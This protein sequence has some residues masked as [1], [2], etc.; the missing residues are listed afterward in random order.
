MD[1]ESEDKQKERE[2]EAKLLD[3]YLAMADAEWDK[4]KLHVSWALR[5]KV[6]KAKAEKKKKEEDRNAKEGRLEGKELQTTYE[7][8]QPEEQVAHNKMVAKTK[9]L[10]TR[11]AAKEAA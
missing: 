9:L 1:A 10:E 11:E 5:N 8:A 4:A 2:Y 3:S 6:Q 7:K